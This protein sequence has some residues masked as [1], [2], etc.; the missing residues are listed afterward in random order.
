MNMQVVFLDYMLMLVVMTFK[1]VFTLD[2][3]EQLLH[4]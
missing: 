2:V 4:S 3:R 1:Y